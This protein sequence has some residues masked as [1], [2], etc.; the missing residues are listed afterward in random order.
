MRVADGLDRGYAQLV[1]GVRC[2]VGDRAVEIVLSTA[3]DAKA[4]P[5]L[6]I[7]SARR[8][9]DLFE[10]TLGRKLRFV[11]APAAAADP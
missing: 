11:L 2:V 4:E 6:E 5:E 9:R 10:E 1:R 3:P 8:K 7:Y